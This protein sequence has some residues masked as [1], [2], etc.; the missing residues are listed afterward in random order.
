MARSAP[1][2]SLTTV[3]ELSEWMR[4]IWPGSSETYLANVIRRLVRGGLLVSQRGI[5]GGYSFARL[6]EEITL[7][8]VVALLEGVSYARCAL[9]PTGKCPVQDGCVNYEVLCDLQKRY[10]DLLGSV[11]VAD[12]AR[13]MAAPMPGNGQQLSPTRGD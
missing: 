10:T 2:E 13:D 1:R 7:Y 5:S 11:T 12:I 3:P 9:T 6:P 8:D 4:G